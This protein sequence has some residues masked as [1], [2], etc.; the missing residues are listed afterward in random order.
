MAF[1]LV[2]A[3]HMPGIDEF[4]IKLNAESNEVVLF[5]IEGLFGSV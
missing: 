2:N 5:N 4:P 1:L 3:I